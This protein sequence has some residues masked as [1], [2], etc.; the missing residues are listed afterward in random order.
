MR[1]GTSVPRDVVTRIAVGVRI[2]PVWV[3]FVRVVACVHQRH[4]GDQSAPGLG[5]I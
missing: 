1:T 5:V 2:F 4:D 3:G